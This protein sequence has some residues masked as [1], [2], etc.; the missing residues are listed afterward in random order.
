M[1]TV[2]ERA[3]RIFLNTCALVLLY[4]ALYGPLMAFE[5]HRMIPLQRSAEQGRDVGEIL[6]DVIYT[7]LLRTTCLPIRAI[8]ARYN[9]FSFQTMYGYPAPTLF[10]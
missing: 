5:V 10:L 9:Y 8:L 6:F 1:T 7:P 3:F 4:V 2:K